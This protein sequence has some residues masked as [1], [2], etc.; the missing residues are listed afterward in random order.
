MGTAEFTTFHG[1]GGL[2]LDVFPVQAGLGWGRLALMLTADELLA[3]PLAELR[4]RFVERAVRTPAGLLE[5]LEQDPRKGARRLAAL[6]RKKLL[7]FRR[8]GI[9]LRNLLKFETQLQRQGYRWIAGVDEAG[10]APLA[11]P[12]VAAAVIL[13]DDYRL[14]GLDDSKRILGERKRE[15]LAARIRQDAVSWAVGRA[16]VDEIDR[17]NIFRAGLLAMQRAVAGLRVRPDFVLVD[18]RTIPELSAP[19]KG[20]IHGDALSASIAAAS[21]IAKTSRDAYMRSLDQVYAGYRFG[22]HK[23]YPT[24]EHFRLLKEIGPL[25]VHRRSFAPVRAALGI[26]PRQ[27]CLFSPEG[28]ATGPGRPPGPAPSPGSQ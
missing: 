20:V 6:M 14:P 28:E 7:E 15:E 21:L 16:E 11:G 25:P 5:A 26:H 24:A 19:Q 8:E 1:G 23:G 10:V 4:A 22:E 27:I 3:M 17:L 13:P 2:A 12:V 18:A 9:R